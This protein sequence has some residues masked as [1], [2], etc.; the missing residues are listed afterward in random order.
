M[1]HAIEPDEDG[2]E[3]WPTVTTVVAEGDGEAEIAR[4]FQRFF[5]ALA[6]IEKTSI[7]PLGYSATGFAGER[8][9]PV[10]RQPRR[11]LLG[12]LHPAPGEVAP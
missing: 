8:D 5:S 2:T 4:S 9:P 3:Y 7:E 11:G 6:Y 12:F 10:S 1:W